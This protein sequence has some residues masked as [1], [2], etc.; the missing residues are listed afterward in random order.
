MCIHKI[1]TFCQESFPQKSI[2]K[3]SSPIYT[4]STDHNIPKKRGKNRFMLIRHQFF[5]Q[6]NESIGLKMR[7]HKNAYP[8]DPYIGCCFNLDCRRQ[9]KESTQVVAM[10]GEAGGGRN[11]PEDENSGPIITEQDVY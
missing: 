8:L 2:I 7:K 11:I 3:D 9:Y 4:F 10:K 5:K 1:N 6:E